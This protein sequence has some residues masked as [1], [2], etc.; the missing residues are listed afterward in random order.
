[1]AEQHRRAALAALL[2]LTQANPALAHKLRVF[3]AAEGRLV[4]GSA[5]FAGGSPATGAR[6]TVQDGQGQTLATLTP[7]AAGRFSYPAPGPIDLVVVAETGDGHRTE[8][9]VAAADLASAF[10]GGPGAPAAGPVPPADGPAGDAKSNA[11]DPVGA[12]TTPAAAPAPTGPAAA[13]DAALE[14]AVERAVARQVRPLRE[15]LAA[16][17]DR[18]TLRDVLGGLGYILGLAGLALWWDA[19]RRGPRP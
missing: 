13:P 7:D 10:A 1:M 18:A 6:V 2:L 4:T 5:Y 9:R 15:E 8:W 3:A 14:A 11:A 19:R 17:Q 12:A 16:A